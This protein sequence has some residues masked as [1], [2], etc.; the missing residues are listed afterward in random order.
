M[1]LAIF[2]GLRDAS[3]IPIKQIRYF[4][5]GNYIV[6]AEKYIA[7]PNQ[8]YLRFALIDFLYFFTNL[9]Q[10]HMLETTIKFDSLVWPI[11]EKVNDFSMHNVYWDTL[12]RHYDIAYCYIIVPNKSQSLC[13]RRKKASIFQALKLEIY[14]KYAFNLNLCYYNFLWTPTCF[15]GVCMCD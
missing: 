4:Q 1:G 15:N 2:Q 13:C 14:L 10:D 6:Q 7:L 12:Y 11:F 8:R 9:K 3:H 5:C